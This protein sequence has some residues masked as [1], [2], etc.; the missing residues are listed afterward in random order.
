MEDLYDSGNSEYEG[1]FLDAL[2]ANGLP[3]KTGDLLISL[4]PPLALADVTVDLITGRTITETLY[5][6]YT[7]EIAGVSNWSEQIGEHWEDSWD[8]VQEFFAGDEKVIAAQ[9]EVN[10]VLIPQVIDN[11]AS[12]GQWVD[13][14]E[15]SVLPENLDS[16]EEWAWGT[17]FESALESALTDLDLSYDFD[18]ESDTWEDDYSEWSTSAYDSWEEDDWAIDDGWS[19][20]DY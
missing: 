19:W 15:Y 5:D 10:A 9:E 3:V 17:A 12:G 4:F 16:G 14:I 8:S 11:Q 18:F 20:T 13:D 1:S 6:F 7:G 2:V